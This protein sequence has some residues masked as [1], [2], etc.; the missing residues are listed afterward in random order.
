MAVPVYSPDQECTMMLG[1]AGSG[2]PVQRLAEVYMENGS[3]Q[4]IGERVVV[5]IE[6]KEEEEEQKQQQ[7]AVAKFMDQKE[8]DGQRLRG[9]KIKERRRAVRR[10]R[11]AAMGWTKASR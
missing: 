2:L 3:R 8:D 4:G 10:R 11:K 7:E 9:E 1:A 6:D 5:L